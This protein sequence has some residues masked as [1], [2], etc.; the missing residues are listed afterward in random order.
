MK[1]ILALVLPL[2][3]LFAWG[4]AEKVEI[5]IERA[6]NAAAG[7]HEIEEAEKADGGVIYYS[8]EKVLYEKDGVSTEIADQVSSLW[9]E[10]EDIYYDSDSVL[11]RYSLRTKETK[12]MV[13]NPCNILGKYNGN[14]ISYS[15]RSIY[16]I[17]GTQKTKIFK[18]G[19]YLNKAVLY[20]NTVY[21]V[22]A[23]NTYAYDLDTLEVKK[24]TRNP[25][26]SRPEI[27]GGDLY[28]ITMENKFGKSSCT[29]SKMTEQGLEAQFTI[30]NIESV[31]GEK[32]VK[33]GMFLAVSKTME[34]STEGNR[35]LYVR[36]GKTAEIDR[37]FSYEIAGVLGNRLCYYK[38]T[39]DYG[40]Y[41][42][43]LT[44][45]YLFDGKTSEKA[46]DIEIGSYETVSGCEYDD[47]LLIEIVYECS[48]ELYKY[49]GTDVEKL[50][51]P[52]S[53]FR[54]TR[55]DI[56]DGKAYISYSDGEESLT[57]LGTVIEL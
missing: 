41:E 29:Y 11:Y 37:D 53:F 43:N 57:S 16:A 55:L 54:V 34:E 10:G 26:M 20:E 27:I 18:D 8:G 44:T 46:F 15:G 45:F 4:C 50:E 1:K 56:I 5:E 32:T 31:T 35:L 21:G 33:N 2:A 39:W 23:V 14:I 36:D 3:M 49:D 51:L 48:T 7:F 28:I 6:E 47:G 40:D 12:R 13:E 24:M 22:P 42:E 19:Y 9:R 17:N 38:N 30:K 52:D 25:E